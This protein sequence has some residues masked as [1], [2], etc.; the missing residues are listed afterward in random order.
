MTVYRPAEGEVRADPVI[1]HAQVGALG[2]WP[3][4]SEVIGVFP[5][6]SATVQSHSQEIRFFRGDSFSIGLQIQNDSDPPS[7]V[8]LG[9]SIVRF[10]AKQGY[11]LTNSNGLLIGNAGALIVKR[12]YDPKEIDVTLGSAGQ[13]VIKI[14][15]RDT[16]DHPPVP[17]VW[18]IEV[19]RAIQQLAS[20]GTVRVTEG[21]DCIQG[22][23]TDF[24]DVDLGDIIEV[25]GRRILILDRI[26]E[27]TL[28]VDFSDWASEDTLD[29]CLYEAQSRTVA[30]GPWTALGDVIR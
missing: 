14:K 29:Y 7:A 23:G 22:T 2:I 18:D 10:A 17:F 4:N 20:A 6:L 30:F 24:S 16:L 11:G 25:Q 19:T 8:D 27:Q 21:S 13:A 28:Q 1:G 5:E 26:D 9:V 3:S 12:S 15:K